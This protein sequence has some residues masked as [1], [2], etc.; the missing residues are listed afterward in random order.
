MKKWGEWGEWGEWEGE[1]GQVNNTKIPC[2]STHRVYI[3]Y[4]SVDYI[5][6]MLYAASI[7]K[8]MQV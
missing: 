7:C 2:T 4:Y 5:F 1:W 6:Y 8:Y 3:V